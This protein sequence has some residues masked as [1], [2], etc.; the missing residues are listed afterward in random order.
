MAEINLKEN[1]LVFCTSANGIAR[2]TLAWPYSRNPKRGCPPRRTLAWRRAIYNKRGL[3]L[4]METRHLDKTLV[5]L[6][7]HAVDRGLTGRV[8]AR[9]EDMGLKITA[10][11]CLRGKPELWEKFYPSDET[12]FKNAG[13]KTLGSCQAAGI[14]VLAVLGTDDPLAIGHL[15]KGWL[16][17]HMSSGTSIAAIL[18]GNEAQKKVRQACGKTLPNVADPGTIRFDFSSDSPVL[19]NR[20]M[21]PVFNIIH[22]SDPDEVGA[23]EKETLLLFPELQ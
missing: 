14:D 16:V 8:L 9:F 5:V 12:W 11:K 10:L 15:I 1:S 3:V 23:V 6:K 20:E 22:A 17:A 21:R 4:P 19:A 7:P 18:E 13:G 2:A